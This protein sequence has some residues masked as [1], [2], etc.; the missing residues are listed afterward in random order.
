MLILETCC[1]I[2][3]KMQKYTCLKYICVGWHVHRKKFWKTIQQISYLWEAGLDG[4]QSKRNKY[5]Y[6]LYCDFYLSILNF[7][8][9]INIHLAMLC[10]S[11]GIQDLHSLLQYVG[12]LVSACKLLVEA[13]G[14]QFHNQGLNLGPLLWECGVLA[15]GSPGKSLHYYFKHFCIFKFLNSSMDFFHNF[16][17]SIKDTKITGKRKEECNRMN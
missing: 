3:C 1:R 6:L 11:L 14:I 10:L 17:M 9:F 4:K 13:C 5:I 2:T 16:T 7:Y 15:T 8:L 12:S